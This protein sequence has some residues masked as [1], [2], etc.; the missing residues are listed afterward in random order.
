MSFIIIFGTLSFPIGTYTD[1]STRH[2]ARLLHPHSGL[3][4]DTVSNRCR[5]MWDSVKP[6]RRLITSRLNA[7]GWRGIIRCP[8][9][10]QQ[11]WQQQHAWR[12]LHGIH[13]ATGEVWF[14]S[15]GANT[16]L[17]PTFPRLSFP[18]LALPSLPVLPPLPL[19]VG[20]I[21]QEVWGR[22]KHLQWGMGLIPIQNRIWC[23]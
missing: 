2:V 5:R 22:Y 23:I 13:S 15:L 6:R 9:Q 17:L 4:P 1:I 19:V 14:L 21:N 3:F 12:G 7:A 18:S 10:Q 8:Q 16:P 20:P 11:Q